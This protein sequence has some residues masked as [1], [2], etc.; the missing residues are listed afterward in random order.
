VHR[1]L[2]LGFKPVLF[3][4]ATLKAAALRFEVCALGDPAMSLGWIFHL[5]W[6]GGRRGF[7]A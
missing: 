3:R 4:A 6:R 2:G 7:S 5:R 1:L